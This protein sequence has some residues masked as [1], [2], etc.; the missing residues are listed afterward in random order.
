MIDELRGRSILDGLRGAPPADVDAL[1]Q[2]IVALSEF[3]SSQRD[4]IASVDLNPVLVRSRGNGVV[5][6]DA[7]IVAG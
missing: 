4:N 7:L 6:L 2:A 5:A 3:A 1:V